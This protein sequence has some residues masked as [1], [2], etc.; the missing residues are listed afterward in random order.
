M[1]IVLLGPPAAGKGT[2]AE[3]IVKYLSIPHISTGDIL[4]QNIRENT[5][6]GKIALRYINKGDLVPD[7]VIIAEIK[8]RLERTDCKDGALLDGF[9]RTLNQAKELDK[10][11]TVDKVIDIKVDDHTLLKRV[12]SRQ[13][14]LKCGRSYASKDDGRC[15]CGGQLYTRADDTKEAFVNRLNNYHK[16]TLP[17]TDYYAAQKK[18]ISVDGKGDAQEVF[19]NI[20]KHL[21]YNLVGKEG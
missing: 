11:F 18:L 17:I 7:K 21:N 10:L 16:L 14:C 8:E 4:R 12:M 20:K 2:Q 1:L 5:E 15:L 13:T 3:R 6:L 19:E 9:P